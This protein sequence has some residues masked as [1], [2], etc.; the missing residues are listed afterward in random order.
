VRARSQRAP[1]PQTV[2]AASQ[3]PK[4]PR[5]ELALLPVLLEELGVHVCC[6]PSD[7]VPVLQRSK[8]RRVLGKTAPTLRCRFC[9]CCFCGPTY[10]TLYLGTLPTPGVADSASGE[11]HSSGASTTCDT[12][13]SGAAKCTIASQG[14]AVVGWQQTR[15][16]YFLLF[17]SKQRQRQGLGPLS[18]DHLQHLV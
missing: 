15:T 16:S 9:G 7:K 8:L 6:R 4:L 1:P 5:Q 18:A 3:H 2:L 17:A 13:P 10:R 12:D 14:V 11:A